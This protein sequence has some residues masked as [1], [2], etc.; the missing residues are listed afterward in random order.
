MPFHPDAR[1]V[2]QIL[3]GVMLFFG[4]LTLVPKSLISLKSG[5][6]ARCV[7]YAVLGTASLV[8]AAVAVGMALS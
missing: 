5:N 3:V 1:E 2:T 6:R 8:L 7:L 4:A